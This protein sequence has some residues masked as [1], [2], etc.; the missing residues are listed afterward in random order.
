M[1][2]FWNARTF[3][4]THSLVR[5]SV[6]KPSSKYPK[7]ALEHD[8]DR[9]KHAWREF[10]SD[11]A[12]DAVYPYLREVYELAA[13]WKVGRDI[14]GR[15]LK[16][17]RRH[18]RAATNE[19]EVYAALIRAGAQG[20][21]LD[22]RTVSKWSRALRFAATEQIIGKNLKRFIKRHGGL[23]GCARQYSWCLSRPA[24]MKK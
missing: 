6:K 1:T 23:N 8:L 15:A 21:T 14:F 13:I 5:V 22:R 2:K 10:Q 9:L 11:R 3:L 18:V 12:R 20:E 19:L 16:I 17:L 4:N 24:K 7:R